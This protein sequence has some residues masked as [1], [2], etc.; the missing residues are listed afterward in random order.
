MPRKTLLTDEQWKRIEPLLPKPKRSPRGGRKPI[1]NR[2]V[3]EGILWVLWTGAPWKELPKRYSSGS[4]CWRRLKR[5]E[6]QGVWLK[7]WRAF[8]AELDAK[9]QLDWSECLADGS[10]A[11]A[12]EG[13]LRRED[14]AGHGHEADGG[15]RRPGSSF[16][17]PPGLCVPGGGDAAGDDAGD[18]EGASRGAWSAADEAPADYCGQGVRQRRLAGAAGPAWDRV[19]RSVPEEHEALAAIRRAEDAAVQTAMESGADLPLAGEL[20]AA[21]GPLRP[22]SD[23]LQCVLPSGLSHD[24]AEAVMKPVLLP[25]HGEDRSGLRDPGL[26]RSGQRRGAL[27]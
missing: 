10:F 2:I 1:E 15:G 19:D 17:Q 27:R 25:S 23:D 4:T 13:A 14:Q 26:P 24:H 18:G 7:A 6:D 5:W 20:P 22:R 12:K 3:L 8:L 21:D 11:P 16:G 9:G